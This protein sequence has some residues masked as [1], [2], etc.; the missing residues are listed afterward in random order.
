MDFLFGEPP[1]PPTFCCV[2]SFLLCV[3]HETNS[4]N[5]ALQMFSDTYC[6]I[7]VAVESTDLMD[8]ALKKN[9]HNNL[10]KSRFMSSY[11]FLWSHQSVMQPGC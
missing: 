4:N 1:P 7:I 10:I 8:E 6:Q 3:A 2:S 11:L 5:G 9:K